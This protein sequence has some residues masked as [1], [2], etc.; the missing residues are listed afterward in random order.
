MT[1][2]DNTISHENTMSF[3]LKKLWGDT[4]ALIYKSITMKMKQDE[5]RLSTAKKYA[6]SLLCKIIIPGHIHVESH[7]YLIKIF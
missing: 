7:L 2:I 3:T 6:S 1:V 4:N 5:I